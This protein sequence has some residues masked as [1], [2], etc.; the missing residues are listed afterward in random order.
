[1]DNCNHWQFAVIFPEHTYF[2]SESYFDNGKHTRS[3]HFQQKE[4]W[5]LTD[6]LKQTKDRVMVIELIMNTLICKRY[7]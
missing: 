1:M 6:K 2:K 4:Q 3:L 7:L 5:R